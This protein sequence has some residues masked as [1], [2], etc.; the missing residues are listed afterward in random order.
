MQHTS[1]TWCHTHMVLLQGTAYP[2]LLPRH[3]SWVLEAMCEWATARQALQTH[4]V[5][6][7][8]EEDS[9]GSACSIQSSRD[10]FAVEA[11]RKDQVKPLD[12]GQQRDWGQQHTAPQA[13][14]P[15]SDLQTLIW[16][17]QKC[18]SAYHQGGVLVAATSRS[19]QDKM[20][21]LHIQPAAVRAPLPSPRMGRP[22][23]ALAAALKLYSNPASRG[24][25]VEW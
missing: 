9:Q 10:G 12:S 24:R 4:A 5:N 16:W 8:S 23:T 14:N 2:A 25:I 13:P 21:A 18:S 7:T 17:G 1:H 22:S 19:R 3:M 20:Q 11:R 15:P 6:A